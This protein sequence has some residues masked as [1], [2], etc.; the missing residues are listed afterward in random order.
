MIA[1]VDQ[2][3]VGMIVSKKTSSEAEN[4]ESKSNN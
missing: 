3:G 2:M 1:K 4:M